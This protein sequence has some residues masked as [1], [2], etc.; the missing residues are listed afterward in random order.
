MRMPRTR[1]FFALGHGDWTRQTLEAL[2]KVKPEEEAAV[3]C[4]SPDHGAKED[5]KRIHSLAKRYGFRVVCRCVRD[6]TILVW[7]KK[8]GFDKNVIKLWGL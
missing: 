1:H 5:V 8:P 4:S 6:N 2:S 7:V 3:L